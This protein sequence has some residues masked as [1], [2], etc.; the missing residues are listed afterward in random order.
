MKTGQRVRNTCLLVAA[1]AALSL[2]LTG[3]NEQEQPKAAKTEQPAKAVEAAKTEQPAKA[4]PAKTDPA[5]AKP[6]DHPA[7]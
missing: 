6:K 3:C 2:G 1:G 4:A 5:K 7:H